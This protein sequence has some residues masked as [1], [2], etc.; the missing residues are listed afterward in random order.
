MYSRYFDSS[1]TQQLIGIAAS[2]SPERVVD[3]FDSRRSNQTQI[4]YF[5]EPGEICRLHINILRR[6]LFLR[7]RWRTTA[8]DRNQALNFFCYLRQSWR[9]IGRGKFDAAIFR[10]IVRSGEIY[11]AIGLE[12]DHL[13]SDSGRWSR[14]GNYQRLNSGC[15]QDFCRH[16]D[17]AVTHVARITTH[18][19]AGSTGLFGDNVAGNSGHGTANIRD[20]ELV[21]NNCPPPGGAK[22]NLRGHA[23]ES[24]VAVVLRWVCAEMR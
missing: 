21:G 23:N 24:L 6:C 17:K 16:L 10:R 11:G 4:N 20:G 15:F 19:N 13:E 22:L 7:G 8:I 14:L 12:P 9:A 1:F 18:D 3:N 5:S 2:S